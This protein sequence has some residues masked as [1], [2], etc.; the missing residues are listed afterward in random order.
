M[1]KFIILPFSIQRFNQA[2]GKIDLLPT[3]PS[4]TY[5]SLNGKKLVL[6][7]EQ[8]IFSYPE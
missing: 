6:M 1:E 3:T 8:R 2:E 5:N 4:L 7:D